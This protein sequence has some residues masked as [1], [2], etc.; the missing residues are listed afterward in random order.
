MRKPR[1]QRLP[2]S[3]FVYAVIYEHFYHSAVGI[4]ELSE[5]FSQAGVIAA[6]A[7]AGE[8]VV[9]VSVAQYMRNYEC[10]T[11]VKDIYVGETMKF[12]AMYTIPEGDLVDGNTVTFSSSDITD[13]ESI[14]LS[15]GD[16]KHCESG[17][18][19]AKAADPEGYASAFSVYENN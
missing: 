5:L 10:S 19:L 11:Y 14:T 4:R 16:F 2:R 12:V 15:T 1:E 18:A 9:T 17:D 13:W 8:D 7:P 6:R 3:F